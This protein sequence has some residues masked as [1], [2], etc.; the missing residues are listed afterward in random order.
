MTLYGWS[1]VRVLTCDNRAKA[2]SL[3]KEYE[4][5]DVINI[6]DEEVQQVLRLKRNA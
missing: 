3:A 4:K 6:V 5:Y 1:E 2:K